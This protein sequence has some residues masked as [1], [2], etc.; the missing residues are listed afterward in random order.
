MENK[1]L[2]YGAISFFST[3]IFI[4]SYAKIWEIKQPKQEIKN[5]VVELVVPYHNRGGDLHW[6]SKG[7]RI[8]INNDKRFIDFPRK[9]WDNTVKKGSLVDLTARKSFPWFGLLDELD[10]LYINDFK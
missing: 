8:K 10:G 1:Y 9:K 3:L 5:A 2:K 6:S 7:N 4:C